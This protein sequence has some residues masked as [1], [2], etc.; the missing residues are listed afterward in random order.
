MTPEEKE[1]IRQWAGRISGPVAINLQVT[2]DDRSAVLE[3]FCTEFQ[4]IAPMV[5]VK[6]QNHSD[7]LPSFWITDNI[8]YQTVPAGLELQPFLD[9]LEGREDESIL[10]GLP[11]AETL[12]RIRV[13]A[14]L[15]VFVA[16]QCPVCPQTVSSMLLLARRCPKI[17]VTVVDGILFPELASVANVRSAPTVILEDRFRWIGAVD[18]QEIVRVIESRDPS[19]LGVQTLQQMIETGNAEALAGMMAQSGGPFPAFMDLLLHPKWPVRLGAMV[20]LEFLSETRPD[21]SIQILEALWNRFE[22]AGNDVKGDILYLLGES[23]QAGM[24]ERL[25]AVHTG[26]YPEAIRE[27]AGDALEALES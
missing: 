9:F 3:T 21:L 6:K 20:A 17:L 12:D 7:P 24:M 11:D 26:D 25:T 14:Y 10:A 8:G 4:K 22:A 13:P 18:L 15:T 2:N 27:A 1:T 16:P 23:K 19:H 5:R